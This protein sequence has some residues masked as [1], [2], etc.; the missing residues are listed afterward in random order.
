[1]A[2]E[3]VPMGPAHWPAVRRF[4]AATW[5]E[6]VQSEAFLRWRYDECP[7]LRGYLALRDGE[8]LAMVTALQRPY[9]IGS[10]SVEV[11]ES[12]DWYCL[13][14]YRG[15]GLGVRVLKRLMEDPEPV[16]VIGGSDDTRELLPKLG[17]RIPD[18][19]VPYT[20]PLGSERVSEIL[21][22]RAKIPPALTRAG[23]ALLRPWLFAPRRRRAPADARVLPV[24]AL[25][26]EIDGLYRA[27]RQ[28]VVPLWRVPQLR[29]L[30]S[31][32]PGLGHF[33]ALYFAQ[34][35]ALRGF[36]LLRIFPTPGGS[37]AQLVD[38]FAPEPD[39]DLFTWMVSETSCVAA[40]FA[41]DVLT[42]YTTSPE[43]GL[44]LR[45]NRFRRGVGLPIHWHDRLRESLPPP[46]FFGGQ[47]GDIPL[48][49]FPSRWW[50]ASE[51]GG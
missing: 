29:W 47:W 12:F 23:F 42:A 24:A 32:F 3:I 14:R 51:P 8:C 35:E 48:W 41:A 43:L 39:P 21:A 25:G 1:M 44:A 37:A 33:V 46:L 27:A 40:G 50:E 5:P 34:G 17:F 6:R 15:S 28:G 26:P 30:A 49:P 31:G 4:A 36:S 2:T 45:R 7:V 16:V 11:R 9:R 20:L 18:T 22:E 13:P 38:L 19:L 10:D